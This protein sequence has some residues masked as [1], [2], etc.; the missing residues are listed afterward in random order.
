MTDVATCGI[1]A[2]LCCRH[3]DTFTLDVEFTLSHQKTT[4]IF[5]PSGSG[6]TTLLRC[7]AGFT[8]S[9]GTVS[10]N[11]QHW[12]QGN[13]CLAVHQRPLAYVFQE[14]SLFA[15]LNVEQNLQYARKRAP[16]SQPFASWQQVVELLG[17][18]P[19]LKHK[20]DQLSGGERQRVAIARALLKQPAILFMDEPLAALDSE[21]KTEVL[22]YIQTL[23]REFSLTIVY[24]T[25][26][27]DE[28]AQLADDLLVIEDGKVL[29]HGPVSQVASD[30]TFAK[31]AYHQASSILSGQV[32][33]ID[34]EYQ[35]AQV[36]CGCGDFWIR[37]TA[38]TMHQ[39]VRLRLLASDISIARERPS[40]STILNSLEATVMAID[41]TAS[42]PMSLVTL[43]SLSSQSAEDLLLAQIT[44]K[45]LDTLG[46]A[47]GQRVWAQIKSVAIVR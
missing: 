19:L 23:Q 1:Y 5:G 8:A 38:F 21:R 3:S 13:Y 6:K 18:A 15:H 14:A 37:N 34:T 36:H 42:Q 33:K 16:K 25:H 28:I 29:A 26:S 7:L 41:A 35:L 31:K 4:A 47:T 39:S 17:L 40:S 11:G 44:R 9:Q 30:I 43:K 32:I 46:L 12:Q 20:P 10:V 22:A 2:Q 27:L 24:V 45:S